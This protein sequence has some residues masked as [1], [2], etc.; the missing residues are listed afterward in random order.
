MTISQSHFRKGLALVYLLGASFSLF[1]Q[2]QRAELD[3]KIKSAYDE[4]KN[5]EETPKTSGQ[6]MTRKE[7]LKSFAPIA[8]FEHHFSSLSQMRRSEIDKE[9]ILLVSGGWGSC[10]SDKT[11]SYIFEQSAR[12]AHK[13]LEK[14][15]H[16]KIVATCYGKFSGDM[17]IFLSWQPEKL[18]SGN[19]KQLSDFLYKISQQK[20]DPTS[21][22]IM[23][24]SYGGWLGLAVA[25]YF[26]KGTALNGLMS[27]DAISKINCRPVE[28][29]W[30][31]LRSSL[32]TWPHQGCV[33][34][35]S[36]FSMSDLN[37]IKELSGWWEN[38]FENQSIYLHS[39]AI[40]HADNFVVNFEV[41]GPFEI[42]DPHRKIFFDSRVWGRIEKKLL[43]FR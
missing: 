19:P 14:N 26:P 1:A 35:P 12:L 3:E 40:K 17:S 30:S 34:A 2:E 28:L 25:S 4:L 38:Y 15:I 11:F 16:Y 9:G 36:D 24:H 10:K 13:A 7:I 39:T 6:E 27:I 20:E 29:I 21:I 18:F 33:E 23:G 31:Y 43:E 22:Y 37:H 41:N 5:S 42:F 32:G 8:Q